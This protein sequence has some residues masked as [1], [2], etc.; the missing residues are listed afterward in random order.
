MNDSS[1]L[2]QISGYIAVIL[3]DRFAILGANSG[4]GLGQLQAWLSD[5]VVWHHLHQPRRNVL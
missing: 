3:M 4:N 2:G 5:D 1:S